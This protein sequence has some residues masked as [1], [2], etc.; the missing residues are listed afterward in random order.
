MYVAVTQGLQAC[1]MP[2][3]LAKNLRLKPRRGALKAA[4]SWLSLVAATTAGLEPISTLRARIRSTSIADARDEL[5]LVVQAYLPSQVPEGGVPY[6]TERP[7]SS[8]Q[9]SVTAEE[10]RQGVVVEMSH[11]QAKL[12]AQTRPMLVAWVERG[13]PNLEFDARLARPQ[14]GMLQGS[15]RAPSATHASQTSQLLLEH[16]T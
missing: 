2:H 7:L 10:L 14:P 1:A 6:A 9:R 3:P 5:R 15:A 4:G 11:P 16:H 12:T 13:R 8:S